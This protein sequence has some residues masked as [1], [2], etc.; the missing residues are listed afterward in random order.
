MSK[1][2]WLTAEGTREI[3]LD[4]ALPGHH[5]WSLEIGVVVRGGERP[6]VIWSG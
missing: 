3:P 4:S 6:L 2:Q 5:H 1:P